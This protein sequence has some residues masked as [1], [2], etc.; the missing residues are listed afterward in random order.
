MEEYEAPR[1][2]SLGSLPELTRGTIFN[3]NAGSGDVVHISGIPPIPIPGD[4]LSS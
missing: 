1:I 3:K 4:G 2:T